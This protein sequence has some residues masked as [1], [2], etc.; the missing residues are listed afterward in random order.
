MCRPQSAGG[1]RCPLHSSSGFVST[2]LARR[3]SGLDARQVNAAFQVLRHEGRRAEAPTIQQWAD[4]LQSKAQQIE[5]AEFGSR[6][7]RAMRNHLVE[8]A[9]EVPDGP[10]FYALQRLDERA[11]AQRQALNDVVDG[12]SDTLGISRTAARRRFAQ[13]RSEVDTSR[14]APLPSGYSARAFRAARNLGLPLDAPT[15]HALGTMT[16][17][18]AEP[19]AEEQ[20]RVRLEETPDSVAIHSIGYHEGRLEIRFRNED[21]SPSEIYAYRNVPVSVWERFQRNSPG[22]VYNHYIRGRSEYQYSNRAEERSDAVARRCAECGQFA[23]SGHSCPPRRAELS[24]DRNSLDTWNNAEEAASVRHYL[25]GEAELPEQATG[26]LSDPEPQESPQEPEVTQE[27]VEAVRRVLKQLDSQRQESSGTSSSREFSEYTA[28][29]Y[30]EDIQ[31]LE[32]DGV[33]IPF[34]TENATNGLLTPENGMGFGVELEFDDGGDYDIRERIGQRLY[35]EG[36]IPSPYQTQY[37]TA[38]ASGWSGWS[39]EEDETVGGEIVSPILYDRPEDWATLK[40]VCDIIRE[41]GGYASRGTGGH[42]HVSSAAL[43]RSIA[44]H[45][46]LLNT[47]AENEDLI[48]RLGTNPGAERH[49]TL[50]WCAPNRDVDDSYI[51]SHR[52]WRYSVDDEESKF[53]HF[54]DRHGSHHVGLNMAASGEGDGSHVEFRQ[55]DGS[56]DPAVIQA[57]VK[58]SAAIVAKVARTPVDETRVPTARA[59]RAVGDNARALEGQTFLDE[60]ERKIAES[61]DF[62]RFAGQMFERREDRVQLAALFNATSWQVDLPEFDESNAYLDDDDWS[63]DDNDDN[64]YW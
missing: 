60:R 31:R 54:R 19:E 34:M 61:E 35:D 21:D 24:I 4:Y 17:A 48:Y 45:A 20:R 27:R 2:R 33:A 12:L 29:E 50:L 59:R 44:R 28:D 42:V 43:G 51:A 57:Q 37:H 62:R 11:V 18:T 41:E 13:L 52:V 9:D 25:A 3:S 10:T 15:V 56:L 22:Y 40:K 7:V 8:A 1:R 6:T 47:V 26:A 39:F 38:A 49:R 64:A 23:G 14:N 58:I 36:I 32:E 63:E 46:E 16:N 30:L 55:F 53:Y 5:S